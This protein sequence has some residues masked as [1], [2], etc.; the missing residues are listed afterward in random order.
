MIKGSKGITL[1]ALVITI[2][3]LVVLVGVTINVMIN[4]GIIVQAQTGVEGY[5][6]EQAT[7]T[8]NAKITSIYI[9]TYAEGQ[10]V[11]TLQVLADE[12]CE[13]DEMQYVEL[14]SKK[15]A[16][17]N[18]INVG[19]AGSIFTKIKAYPYEFEIDSSLRL[20]S[21]DGV[22]VDD[23]ST[24]TS[25][26]VSREEYNALLSRV[27]TLENSSNDGIGQYYETTFTNKEITHN[28]QNKVASLTLPAGKYVLV[29]Y[30]FY[31]GKDLRFHLMLGDAMS[32]AYDN[33]GW[34]QMNITNIVD[35]TNESNN[36]D[37]YV[38][39]NS[40]DITL[41]KGFLRAIKIGN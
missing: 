25:D 11:P 32:S 30:A 35:L 18:K 16:S 20:A 41:N 29:G 7:E 2:I 5:N 15:T 22:K 3:I 21:I 6:K 24:D 34:V 19:N 23:N 40:K 1:V 39:V 14:I 36:I 31:E 9:K 13:D 33:N 26:T 37:F 10:T 12:L 28:E 27:Q 17:L 38:W 8:M 4:Q